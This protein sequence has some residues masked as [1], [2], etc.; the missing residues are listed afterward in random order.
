MFPSTSLFQ[1][2]NQLTDLDKS[3]T[4]N[5]DRIKEDLR[6][7]RT[8]V[9]A[10][11][12]KNNNNNNHWIFVLA[13]VGTF[14]VGFLVTIGVFGVFRSGAYLGAQVKSDVVQEKVR[15]PFCLQTIAF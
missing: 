2:Q 11:N 8:N 14:I 5:L 1:C 3:S 12:T 7:C 6:Q 4:T 9:E 15:V 10:N 13:I